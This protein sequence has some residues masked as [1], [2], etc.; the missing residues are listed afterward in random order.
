M[1][2]CKQTTENY[3]RKLGLM[4]SL[5]GE[6]T[7]SKI[8]LSPFSIG[9]NPKEK[10]MP[11]RGKIFPVRLAPFPNGLHAQERDKGV[12]TITSLG[13]KWQKINYC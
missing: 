10:N 5:A 6:A 11:L 1:Y 3:R 8:I 9:S 12:T 2:N 7:M 4:D 13:K